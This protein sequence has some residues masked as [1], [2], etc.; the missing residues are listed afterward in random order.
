MFA[1]LKLVPIKQVD[2]KNHL[3]L[4]SSTGTG[5][6]GNIFISTGRLFLQEGADI[7]S[8]NFGAGKGGNITV[9]ASE[10]MQSEG[11]GFVQPGFASN[12]SVTAASTF[13]SAN[14]GNVTIS[15]QQIRLLP[16]GEI[17]SATI[18]S[19]MGGT[20]RLNA[21]DLVEVIGSNAISSGGSF[22]GASS[23][24]SGKAGSIDVKTSRLNVRD[25]PML[26]KLQPAAI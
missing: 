5:N 16:G 19:G 14:A 4:Q 22:V 9:N 23:F 12:P 10:L 1:L 13:S 15:S 26:A 25:G 8:F 2:S 20:V 18:G 24:G 7:V 17:S 11:Y 21:S 6:A 3:F